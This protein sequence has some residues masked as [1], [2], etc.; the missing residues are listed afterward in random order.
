MVHCPSK[1]ISMVLPP[2]FHCLGIA[3][4][5]SKTSSGAGLAIFKSK[6]LRRA[7]ITR[8]CLELEN[9]C[10]KIVRKKK[11]VLKCTSLEDLKKFKWLKLMKEWVREA[12]TLCK[13]LKANAMPPQFAVSQAY[14]WCSWCHAVKVKKCTNAYCSIRC[15]PF[16]FS[17]LNR[18]KGLSEDLLRVT[19]L[20][21]SKTSYP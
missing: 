14:H 13:V 17:W 21:L 6:G 10:R 19:L 1:T 7:L 3:L 9:E 12:P 8:S 16:S 11:S 15:W 4:C 18:K 20:Q 2:N 5:K